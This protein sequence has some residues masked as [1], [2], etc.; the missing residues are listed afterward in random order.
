MA[1]GP[2]KKNAQAA[3]LYETDFYRWSQEQGQALRGQRATEVDWENVAEEIESLGRSD[4]RSLESNLNVVLL[5]LLKWQ[6]QP[7]Q[8]KPGW[9]SSIIEHRSRIR[10]LTNESP[11]LRSYPA[12]VLEEEYSLARMKAAGETGIPDKHFPAA[13]PFTIQQVLD[14]GF[15]PDEPK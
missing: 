14:L 12:E 7:E 9:Q 2:L 6:Y 11:S 3:P 10:K 4:K 8:R 5:H 13:C 1:I 15:Y